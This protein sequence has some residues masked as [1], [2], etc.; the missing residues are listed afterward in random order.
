MSE[1][2]QFSL[3]KPT[4]DT[5]FHIDF[6]WWKQHDS[7]WRVFLFNLLCETHQS[8]YKDQDENVVIDFID[9]KTAEVKSVDGMLHTLLNHCAK[10]DRFYFT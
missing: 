4:I 1:Q 2:T 3:V 6:E 9:P 5:P 7:D 8:V 10:M